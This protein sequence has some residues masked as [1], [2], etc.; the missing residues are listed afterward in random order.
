MTYLFISHNLGVIE[1]ISDRVAVMYLG[2]I[3]ELAEKRALFAKPAHPYTKALLAAIP[4]LDPTAK[5]R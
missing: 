2:K 1:H 3:V 5:K 4:S